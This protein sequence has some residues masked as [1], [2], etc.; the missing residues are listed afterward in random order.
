MPAWFYML[1]LKSGILYPGATTNIKKRYQEHIAG[2]A[3]RTTRIDTPVE[4][5]YVEEYVTFAEARRREAQVKRWTR[6]KKE[7]LA[8]GDIER[9]KRLARGIP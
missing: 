6:A 3:C 9:L 2:R 8:A 7:A 1:R 5:I 4:V